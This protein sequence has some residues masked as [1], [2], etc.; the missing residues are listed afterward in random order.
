MCMDHCKYLELCTPQPRVKSKRHI[1]AKSRTFSLY[2]FIPRENAVEE[3][4]NHPG[5]QDIEVLAAS[6]NDHASE[7]GA[8]LAIRILDDKCRA[9][10]HAIGIDCKRLYWLDPQQCV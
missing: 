5:F 3:G 2:R 7:I 8:R 4:H 10:A 1:S 9:A 6:A